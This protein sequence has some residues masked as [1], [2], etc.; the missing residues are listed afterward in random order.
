MAKIERVFCGVLII[1]CFLVGNN[2]FAQNNEVERVLDFS[3]DVTINKDASLVVVETIKI[4]AQGEQIKHGIYRDFPT[5]YKDRT[6]VVYNVGFE[7]INVQRDGKP[8]DYHIENVANGIRVYFGDSN[9]I[10]DPGIYTYEF[11]YKTNRQ[12]GFFPDHDELYWNVA[13]NGWDFAIDHVS[14]KIRLF[15]GIDS[16]KIKTE[17]YTGLSGGTGK[18]YVVNIA[19]EDV[20][21]E[22]TAKLNPKE[23]LTVVVG[24]PKGYVDE[25]TRSEKTI[26]YIIDNLIIIITFFGVLIVFIYYFYAWSHWGRDPRRG[27]VVPQYDAP[28]GLSPGAIRYVQ[29]Y[30]FDKKAFSSLILN[31]A[32]HGFLKISEDNGEYILEK[33]KD[34]VIASAEENSL[35]KELFST[36][37][38]VKLEQENYKH[39]Q[40]AEGAAAKVV[41]DNYK[42][43]NFTFNASK[44]AIGV[45]ASFVVILVFLMSGSSSAIGIVEILFLLVIN[46]IFVPLL[47]QRTIVGRKLVDEIEG[48]KWFLSVTEKDRL[49]FHNPPGKTPELFE[50]FLPYALALEVEQKW[51]EQFTEIFARLDAQGTSYSPS[52]YMGS[53]FNALAI[54]GF[55]S[56]FGGTFSS[57]V[58]SAS[59]PPGSSSGF[60]GGSSG[61]GGGGGGG[62]G[63]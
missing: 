46:F 27:T 13:G 58:S 14:A 45:S 4:E 48:F 20:N 12:I 28:A 50:K 8:E 38:K 21:I 51:A 2:A 31:L 9:V 33:T 6:G 23:G 3:S 41:K 39:L 54:S 62:G 37:D 17:G 1:W 43:E 52:W 55:A 26:A 63:W 16:V 10:L 15:S 19:G 44:I 61:G 59:T 22:S 49:N 25:P 34:S 42:K 40:K 29:K 60:G 32:V 57:A 7:I 35:F 53:N 30:F 5:K 36:G 56:S 24:W 47:P 11:T 18:A